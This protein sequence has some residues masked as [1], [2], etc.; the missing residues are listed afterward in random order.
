MDMIGEGLY[1]DETMIDHKVNQ[2][3]FES[4]KSG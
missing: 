4:L 2:T 1:Y 3:G